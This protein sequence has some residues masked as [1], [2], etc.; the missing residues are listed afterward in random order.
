MPTTRFHTCALDGLHP[1]RKSREW[2]VRYIEL[3]DYK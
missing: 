2:I 1:A 3:A